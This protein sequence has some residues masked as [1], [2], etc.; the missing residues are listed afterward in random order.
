MLAAG[1]VL[2]HVGIGAAGGLAFEG[3]PVT[4]GAGAAA[5]YIL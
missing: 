3:N 4:G 1:I 2:G 5:G